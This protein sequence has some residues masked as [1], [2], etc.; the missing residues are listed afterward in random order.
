MP[1]LMKIFWLFQ[2]REL[3][4]FHIHFFL[5][6]QNPK[7][8]DHLQ[9]SKH[10]SPLGKTGQWQMITIN[11]NLEKLFKVTDYHFPNKL[12]IYFLIPKPP[13]HPK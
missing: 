13:V 9:Y 7:S 3:Y 8:R 2:T 1:L 5:L 10:F 11:E 4:L 6:T 12:R